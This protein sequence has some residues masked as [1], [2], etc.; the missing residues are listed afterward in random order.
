VA[1][2]LNP[3]CMVRSRYA[4]DAGDAQAETTTPHKVNKPHSLALALEVESLGACVGAAMVR[5]ELRMEQVPRFDLLHTTP[6][7]PSTKRTDARGRCKKASRVRP[8]S[9]RCRQSP[10]AEH[11]THL[12][13]GGAAA[14]CAEAFEVLDAAW[15]TH[16]PFDGVLGFS[17]KERRSSHHERV[18]W[19]RTP[20]RM[21]L[22][23]PCPVVCFA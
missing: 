13:A 21:H 9:G 8:A 17:G 11:V 22:T 18:V 23:V 20:Y 4:C 6:V 10:P 1:T 14:A 16:G 15:R 19:S 2:T 7:L 12:G 3:L 5:M